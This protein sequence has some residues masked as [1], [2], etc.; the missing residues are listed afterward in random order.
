[1]SDAVSLGKASYLR[2]C[3]SGKSFMAVTKEH[4]TINVPD[5]AVHDDSEVWK[6]GDEGNLVVKERFADE[7]GYV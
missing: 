2:K 1:M 7:K 5:W 4:G 6:A 3:K